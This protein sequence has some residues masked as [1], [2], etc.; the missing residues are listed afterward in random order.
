MRDG[1][2]FEAPQGTDGSSRRLGSGPSIAASDR[3]IP[4]GVPIAIHATTGPRV[5]GKLGVDPSP[6]RVQN[7]RQCILVVIERVDRDPNLV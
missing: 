5:I 3:A 1:L 7:E 4:E 6:R 2:S